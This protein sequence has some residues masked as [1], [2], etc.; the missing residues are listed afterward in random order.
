MGWFMDKNKGLS[1][2]SDMKTFVLNKRNR[3]IRGSFVNLVITVVILTLVIIGA[4]NTWVA[5][6]LEKEATLIIGFFTASMGIWAY[7][8]SQEGDCA[9][10][11][12]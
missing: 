1:A 7:R 11:Q 5:E 4:F 3:T 9:D 2:L 6:N 12:E 10:R 8:K